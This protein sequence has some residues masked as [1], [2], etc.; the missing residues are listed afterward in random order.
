MIHNSYLEH[1][2]EGTI[3]R[4]W[5]WILLLFL[6]PAA[7]TLALQWY[8]YIVVSSGLVGTGNGE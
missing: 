3:V 5:A 8:I 7:T 1:G 4:P 6:G 2:G